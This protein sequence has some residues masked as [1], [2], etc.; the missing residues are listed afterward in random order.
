MVSR[1]KDCRLAQV[2]HK[3]FM[4]NSNATTHF[5][6]CMRQ[7]WGQGIS[8]LAKERPDSQRVAPGL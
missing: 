6:I 2:V 4:L 7:L 1:M 3:L 8:H 5:L